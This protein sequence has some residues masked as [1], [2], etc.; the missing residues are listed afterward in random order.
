METQYCRK[1][2]TALEDQIQRI[3]CPIQR[4]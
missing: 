1:C 2:F 3:P 4:S